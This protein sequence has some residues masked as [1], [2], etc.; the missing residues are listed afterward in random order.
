MRGCFW[1]FI[2]VRFLLGGSFIS[3]DLEGG[4]GGGYF[5]TGGFVVGGKCNKL[6]FFGCSVFMTGSG[7]FSYSTASS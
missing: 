7:T 2:E 4:L 5:F 3:F 1:G 6:F